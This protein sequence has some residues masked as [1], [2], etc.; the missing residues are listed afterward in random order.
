VYLSAHM[1]SFSAYRAV[2]SLTLASTRLTT[3]LSPSGDRASACG[4][5]DGVVAYR[6]GQAMRGGGAWDAGRIRDG[7]R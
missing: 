5:R 1:A 2:R 3:N 6:P 4:H 7:R